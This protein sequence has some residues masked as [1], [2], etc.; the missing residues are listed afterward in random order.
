MLRNFLFHQPHV[1]PEPSFNTAS[2]L[3]QETKHGARVLNVSHILIVCVSAC[4]VRGMSYHQG[5]K[6]RIANASSGWCCWYGQPNLQ[7]RT[8][9]CASHAG[10][11]LM[12]CVL[13][14]SRGRCRKSGKTT[15]VQLTLENCMIRPSVAAQ[16]STLNVPYKP[17]KLAGEPPD[18]EALPSPLLEHIL[19]LVLVPLPSVGNVPLAKDSI[20]EWTS[21]SCVS[22]RFVR[23]LCA[24][25]FVV[26][27]HPDRR[28]GEASMPD[29]SC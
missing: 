17:V 4:A 10:S 18:I 23:C 12:L 21:L 28:Q 16:A 5:C 25:L 2:I 27:Q 3:S 9:S 14:V 22:K 29:K 26:K 15:S 8:S 24:W 1:Q 7:T 13:H 20:K 19:Q 6:G 11:V